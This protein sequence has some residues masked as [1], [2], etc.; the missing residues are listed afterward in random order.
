MRERMSYFSQIASQ[1]SFDRHQSKDDWDRAG[2]L[3]KAQ[4]RNKNIQRS[5]KDANDGLPKR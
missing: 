3:K 1:H 2:I 5:K 4:M